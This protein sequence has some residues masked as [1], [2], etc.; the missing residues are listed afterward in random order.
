[1]RHVSIAATLLLL[2][3]TLPARADAPPPAWLDGEISRNTVVIKLGEHFAVEY[4][5]AVHPKVSVF[6]GPALFASYNKS[7][8]HTRSELGFGGTVG[9]RFFVTGL[10]PEGLFVGPLLTLGYS[11]V[12]DTGDTDNTSHGL[13]ITSGAM[14][15]YT[16]IFGQVFDLSLGAG[17]NYVNASTSV[18][19]GPAPSP[20]EASLR[21]AIGVAF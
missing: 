10:A 8:T 19:G 3:V 15:G 17:A 14:V 21:G 7:G 2:L 13:R 6:V 11:T 18:A 5:R 4:E 1:M 20:V 16:W 12:R 9:A